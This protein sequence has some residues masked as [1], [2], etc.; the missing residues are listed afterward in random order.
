LVAPGVLAAAQNLFMANNIVLFDKVKGVFISDIARGRKPPPKKRHFQRK[1]G[2]GR[3]LRHLRPEFVI[4][5]PFIFSDVRSC[6][7]V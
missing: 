3:I 1:E 7:M 5:T 6:D 4:F 2:E